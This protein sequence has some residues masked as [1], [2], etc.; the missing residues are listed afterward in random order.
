MIK[1]NIVFWDKLN[2]EEKNKILIRPYLKNS[3]SVSKIVSEIINNVYQFRD[4]AINKYSKIFD[5]IEV[6]DFSLNLK[7]ISLNSLNISRDVEDSILIAFKNIKLFH[8]LKR[9]LDYE[10]EIQPGIKC[11]QLVLPIESVGLYVPGGSTS[12]FST[13]L[14]LAIPANIAGCKNIVICSPPPIS[15]ELLYVSK[16]CGVNKIFQVG[17]AQAIAGLSFGTKIMPKVDKIFGPGNVYVT[18]AKL[19]VSKSFCNVDIDMIAGPSELLVLS[20]HTANPEFIVS[21]LC[22]QAE[23]GSSSQVFLVTSCKK[24][25]ISTLSILLKKMNSICNSNRIKESIMNSKIIYSKNMSECINIVNRYGPEHLIIQT[26]S[27]EKELKEI[28]NAG[29]IF[30]GKWS[31]VSV[32]DYASGTNHVLPTSGSV[33]TRS[34]LSV[35]DFQKRINVQKLNK[36]GLKNLAFTVQTLAKKEKMMEHYNAVKVRIDYLNSLKERYD[37]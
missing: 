21:D 25:A 33:N 23:H 22:S 17:G 8:K 30:L 37:I 28:V 5:K 1:K 14:M 32:G 12:L 20:D 2:L 18:E 29:S 27:P 3:N 11:S 26:R 4:K 10:V 9:K 35:L 36:R 15:K 34:G 16:L 7:K 24:M 19:Q 13:A 31:P 6:K